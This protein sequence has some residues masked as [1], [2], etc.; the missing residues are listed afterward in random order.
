MHSLE[1]TT[2]ECGAE[3]FSG[4]VSIPGT[5]SAK[6]WGSDL[7]S[8]TGKVPDCDGKI[9]YI[10]ATTTYTS[11]AQRSTLYNMKK[12]KNT[13]EMQDMADEIR[14]MLQVSQVHSGMSVGK[15]E[16]QQQKNKTKDTLELAM[17]ARQLAAL[18]TTESQTQI[19]LH[20]FRDVQALQEPNLSTSKFTQLTDNEVQFVVSSNIVSLFTVW[21]TDIDGHFSDN[22]VTVHPCH[23]VTV[24]FKAWR[25]I[26]PA[27]LEAKITVTSLAQNLGI[28]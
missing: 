28:S 8:V 14:Q 6:V 22:S 27:E 19:W 18:F 11:P 17:A 5:T 15:A 4:T 13:T 7:Y 9:C 25:P 10:T 26:T 24:I 3:V 20:S 23:P 2:D 12:S 21:D 1:D 16:N